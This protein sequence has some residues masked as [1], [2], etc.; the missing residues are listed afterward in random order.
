MPAIPSG[1]TLPGG[2]RVKVKLVSYERM[3][4]LAL[5]DSSVQPDDSVQA[6]YDDPGGTGIRYLLEEKHPLLQ[7]VDFTHEIKHAMAEWEDWFLRIHGVE[8][9][10]EDAAERAAIRTEHAGSP[11]E[12]GAGADPVVRAPEAVGVG[13]QEPV[14]GGGVA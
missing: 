14:L 3:Q 10:L 8:E 11:A 7:A 4:R 1:F 5:E 6:F 13:G 2:Y 9:A 12:V